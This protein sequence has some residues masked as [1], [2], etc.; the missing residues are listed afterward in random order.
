MYSLNPES[1]SE[2]PINRKSFPFGSVGIGEG[3]LCAGHIR[4]SDIDL[5]LILTLADI[6]LALQ[7]PMYEG[8]ELHSFAIGGRND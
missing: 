1:V 2:S 7:L 3:A 5:H 8:I 6:S 4:A